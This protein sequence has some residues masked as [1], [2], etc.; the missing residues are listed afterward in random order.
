MDIE[1]IVP[2]DLGRASM[3]GRFNGSIEEQYNEWFLS[4]T[5]PTSRAILWISVLVWATA[6]FVLPRVLDL[7]GP[8]LS[9]TITAVCWGIGLPAVL[10]PVLLGER[11]MRMWV[12]PAVL[13]LTTMC[14][15][16]GVY[17]TDADDTPNLMVSTIGFFMFIAPI[18]QFPFRSTGI[19]LLLTVPLAVVVAIVL[20]DRDG[21]WNG[22]LNYQLWLLSSTSLIVLGIS[23]VIENTLRGRFVDEQIIARQQEELLSSRALIRRYAPPAVADRLEHGDTTV[24]SPQ[25]RRV[26]VL[27]A[28][29]VGF[30]TLADRLDPEALA[31]IVNEYLGSVAQ[32][33]ESH[34]GTLNEFAGDGVM[35]IFGAP[36]E[37][38]AHEQVTS[39]LGAAQELQRSLP[40]W[41]QRWYELG[42]D[43][44]LKARIGINTGVLSIGTFGSAVRATYT[45]IGLQT[46]IAARIQSECRPGSVLLSKTSW[47]LVSDSVPCEPRGEVQ[48]KGV[49]FPIAMYEP[50]PA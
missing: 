29:V 24:D 8:I 37:M 23:L 6:P 40:V 21:T 33:I 46:N 43:Q 47:H 7:D 10:V 14:G 34:G 26:T 32:I 2:A 48:V 38:E 13:T 18:V 11:H 3:L 41:S 35:A 27:F 20:A 50:L 19:V 1:R 44:D 45:G 25:R 4:R 39:A 22:T 12:Q 16:L 9:F 49:H 15:L 28:D 31:E 36:D 30:T 42:I 17:L 5:W